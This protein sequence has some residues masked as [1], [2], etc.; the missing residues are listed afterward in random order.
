[1]N[2]GE[3]VNSTADDFCSTPVRGKGLFFVSREALPG[4][5][6]LGDIYFTRRDR[7]G[8]WAEPEHL[9]CA[10][11]GPNGPLDEQ[12]PSYVELD[13]DAFLYFSSSSA[14][15]PGDIYVSERSGTGA[16]ARLPPSPS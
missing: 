13:G 1:M 11:A 15:V 10:P 4:S 6:G 12:G 14:V 7:S 2:L 16:S 8:G 9:A 5:C 3:P